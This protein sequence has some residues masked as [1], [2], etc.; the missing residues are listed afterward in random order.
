MSLQ[1]KRN[2]TEK[3]YLF[4]GNL[5]MGRI[6]AISKCFI[7]LDFRPELIIKR[8]ECLTDH[9]RLHATAEEPYKESRSKE[10][11]GHT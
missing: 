2:P 9:E 10:I 1:I 4:W 8:E 11:D 3:L 5:Y 6:T 7:D